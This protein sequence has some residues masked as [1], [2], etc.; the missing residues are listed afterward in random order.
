MRNSVLILRVASCSPDPDRCDKRLSISSTKM[1]LGA[2]ARAKPNRALTS[3]SDSPRNLL[4]KLLAEMEK[5]VDRDSV[6]TARASIVLP[7]PGGPNKSMPLVGSRRPMKRSGLRKGYT[8]ASRNAALAISKPAISLQCTSSP[9]TMMSLRICFAAASST[10]GGKFL[11]TDAF[12]FFQAF[13]SVVSLPFFWFPTASSDDWDGDFTS[14]S[15]TTTGSLALTRLLARGRLLL[16]SSE[17]LETW[18]GELRLSLLRDLLATSGSMG[19]VLNATG[20]RLGT[21]FLLGV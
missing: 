13:S 6:A 5:N 20:L 1:M 4:V 17:L 21:G 16:S 2:R 3:F 8:T 14:G 12:L 15:P 18:A 9:S 19:L 7:V 11:R 10:P